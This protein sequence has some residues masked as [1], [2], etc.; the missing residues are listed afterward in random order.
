MAN[1]TEQNTAGLNFG[2]KIENILQR[3]MQIDGRFSDMGYS[4][5]NL[6]Q[7]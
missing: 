2:E 4:F 6:V 7:T 3:I 5:R 1:N